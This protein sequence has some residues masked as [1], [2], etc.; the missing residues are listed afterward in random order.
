MVIGSSLV[1]AGLRRCEELSYKSVIPDYYPKF[2]FIQACKKGIK[3]PFEVPSE[4][5]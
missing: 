2:G 3:C 5:F 4:A 1:K